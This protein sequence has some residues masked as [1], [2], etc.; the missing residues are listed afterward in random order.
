MGKSVFV[1]AFLFM[2]LV[3]KAQPA[4]NFSATPVSGCAP[5][6]VM[7]NDLS[8]GNPSGW[9]WDLGNGTISFL[10]NPSV[11]YFNP[12]LYTVKLVVQNAQGK[13]SII[14][15]QY[16]KIF[17]LPQPAFSASTQ[18]GCYPLPVQFQDESLAGS[19][20]IAEWLWDFGDGSTATVQNPSHTYT[21]T[22][23]F[24]VSLKVKNT[25]G[26]EKTLTRSQF[27][28]INEGVHADFSNTSPNSC[29]APITINFTNL[30]TG[31]GVLQYAWNFGDGTTSVLPNPSHTYSGSGSYTISL[32][33]FNSNGCRDTM[34]RPGQVS[35]GNIFPDFQVPVLLCTETPVIFTNTS[36]P[37]P[38]SVSW[39]FGDLTS[40]TLLN[41]VKSFDLSGIY[42]VKMVANFGS[43]IDSVTK[44]VTVVSRPVTAFNALPLTGCKAPLLVQFTNSSLGAI[45]F[46]WYFGDGD[47]ASITSPSHLYTAPGVYTVTLITTNA[48][49][50]TDT[51]VRNNYIHILLPVVTINNLP[52]EGCAPF[53][54]TFNSSL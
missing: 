52:Q 21:S 22:G 51:V 37:V 49:G 48:A 11:T 9:K 31:S 28:H 14:R 3:G 38:A 23:N 40:T 8:T 54:W 7:F 46:K 5:L 45:N 36:T 18:T 17:A 33:V 29:T 41:P 27:I 43:C 34:I 39:N 6:L 26:C 42:Q 15:Q 50:C 1:L 24:N 44:S 2:A 12:G 35:V 20:T 53:T 4:A 10:Q 32:I 30:S 25:N 16:I 47:S 19:G 13:D